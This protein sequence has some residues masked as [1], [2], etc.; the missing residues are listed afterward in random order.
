MKLFVYSHTYAYALECPF[1]SRNPTD[2]EHFRKF[3]II[4]YG[5][6]IEIIDAKYDFE[7]ENKNQ[8]ELEL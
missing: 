3:S 6:W 8:L 4:T 7:L 2:L 5:C 1:E